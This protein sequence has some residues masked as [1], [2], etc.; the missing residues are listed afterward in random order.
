MSAWVQ[1]DYAARTITVP[2]TS[3]IDL[4]GIGKGFAA[5][6]VAEEL[7]EV[8]AVGAVVN[9]GG[10]VRVMGRPDDATSWFLGIEDPRRAPE[11]VAFLHLEDGGVATSGITV[12]HWT[13]SDG[14]PAHHLIDPVTGRPVPDASLSATVLAADTATAEAFATAAMMLPA[15]EAVDMLEAV[16]LAGLVVDHQGLVHR[17]TTLQDFEQ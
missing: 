14:S 7:M 1:V 13:T 6:L 12:R 15:A 11:H 5:D 9:V 3:A 10:D 2:A 16:R 4:G 17:T 8:G